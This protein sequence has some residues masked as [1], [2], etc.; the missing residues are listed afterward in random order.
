MAWYNEVDQDDSREEPDAA[1]G[2]E[3]DGGSFGSGAVRPPWV[4]AASLP[5]TAA[6]TEPPGAHPQPS[7]PGAPAEVLVPVATSMMAPPA[8]PPAPAPA[9]V[10]AVPPA[11]APPAPAP[12]PD[13][14]T[15]TST[16]GPPASPPVT[17]S[18]SPFSALR[19]RTASGS[20]RTS[21]SPASTTDP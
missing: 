11:A 2:H 1:K 13:P 21:P 6:G 8:H 18:P 7:S 17:P 4:Q 12:L 20:A 10:T 3:E 9:P 19:P 16:P 15:E 5:E 14:S